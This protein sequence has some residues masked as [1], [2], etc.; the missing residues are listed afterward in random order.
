MKLLWIQSSFSFDLLPPNF[1]VFNKY[2]CIIFIADDLTICA[3][4]FGKACL[5]SLALGKQ[6]SIHI[7]TVRREFVDGKILHSAVHKIY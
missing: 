7:D 4:D 2:R 6:A 3:V 5:P 1:F